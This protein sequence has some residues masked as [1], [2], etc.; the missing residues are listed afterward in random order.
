MKEKGED[1]GNPSQMGPRAPSPWIGPYDLRHLS[2]A[3]Y[4]FFKAFLEKSM[5]EIATLID[6]G[7]GTCSMFKSKKERGVLGENLAEGVLRNSAPGTPHRDRRSYGRA[8]ELAEDPRLQRAEILEAMWK[9]AK[10][11]KKEDLGVVMEGLSLLNKLV[12]L[13]MVVD[14]ITYRDHLLVDRRA[15]PQKDLELGVGEHVAWQ[16]PLHRDAI[17]KAVE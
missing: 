16:T 11:I 10:V 7:D 2:I 1:R 8:H 12:E 9:I 15:P 5:H 3:F 14:S 6:A 4:Y 17:R 13:N